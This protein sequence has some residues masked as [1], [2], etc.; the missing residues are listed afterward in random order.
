MLVSEEIFSKYYQS[1][2]GLLEITGNDLGISA[3]TFVEEDSEQLASDHPLLEKCIIQLTEYFK[4]ERKKF[5]LPLNFA[6]TAFQNQVWSKLLLIPFGKTATYLD[7][8]RALEDENSTRAVGNANSKNKIA[9]VVPC[10]RVIG[11]N[12]QLTGYMGGLWR[13][14]WL[15]KHEAD[16]A[17]G[18]QIDLFENMEMDF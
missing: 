8:S 4:G 5:D 18:K 14:K 17:F 9:I 6:G 16:I 11:S 15:L 3:I 13:K 7:I 2:L 10:H 12:G 1:P